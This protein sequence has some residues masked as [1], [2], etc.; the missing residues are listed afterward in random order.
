MTR[1]DKSKLL[2]EPVRFRIVT[3]LAAEEA[4]EISFNMIKDGL[5][6]TAGNLSIQLKKLEHENLIKTSR[7][8]R[9]NKPLT[10]VYITK[11]G[12]SLLTGHL[13]EMSHIL[14]KLKKQEAHE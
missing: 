2:Y 12:Y 1:K 10:T 5:K 9:D 6:L 11:K 14:E 8:F 13:E 3:F 4:K 7:E